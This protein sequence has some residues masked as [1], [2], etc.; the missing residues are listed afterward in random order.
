MKWAEKISI[1]KKNKRAYCS[2][3]L[4]IFIFV[5]SLFSEL[6][7]NDKPLIVKY[8]NE[9]YFPVFHNYSD[10]FWGGD[11]PTAANYSDSLIQNNIKQNGWLIMP[12]IPYSF[13]TVDYYLDSATPSAPSKKHWLGTDEEGRDVLARILYGIRLSLIF[14]LVLTFISS[15]IGIFVGAVQGYFGGKTDIILQRFIEIWDSLPQLF[16]LIIIASVFLPTFLSLLV[17]LLLFSWTGLTGMVRAEFLR[18]RNFEYVKAAQVLG[19]GNFR[20][21][22]K[23]ILPNALVTSI[24]FIPF[25]MAEAITSL[26]ALDFLGLGLSQDYPSLGDLVR[27]GKDNLQAPWIGV[28]IFVVLSGLLSMLIFIGEGVRDVFDTRKNS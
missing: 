5:L 9:L 3:L 2:F 15:A 13:N 6:I 4:L 8:K 26:S 27:Q 24:T 25:I 22:F 28:S 17:I 11:F 23:H 20:I 16:I 10:E 14:A 19:V 7:S 1:F 18:L 21:M 12:P